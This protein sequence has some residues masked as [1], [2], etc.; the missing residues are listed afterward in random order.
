MA[1][2]GSAKYTKLDPTKLDNYYRPFEVMYL[3]RE[4]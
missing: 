2:D 3:P 1:P 4:R